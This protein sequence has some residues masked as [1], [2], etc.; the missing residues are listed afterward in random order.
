VGR[1]DPRRDRCRLGDCFAAIDYFENRDVPFIVGV[2]C[3]NGSAAH[4]LFD[5]R[6]ALAVSPHVPMVYC[7]ARSRA[8]GKEVLVALLQEAI[9]RAT[10]RHSDRAP[11]LPAPPGGIDRS[12]GCD[13]PL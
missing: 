7:D 4:D 10:A 9:G 6:E 2:N 1:P 13:D 11:A 5:V 12:R 8:S 3:F